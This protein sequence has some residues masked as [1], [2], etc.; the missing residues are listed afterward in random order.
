MFSLDFVTWCFRRFCC[1]CITL[2]LPCFKT[3]GHT[4]LQ[5]YIPVHTY[6]IWNLICLNVIDFAISC[7]LCLLLDFAVIVVSVNFF[8]V[9]LLLDFAVI[10]LSF[11]FDFLLSME[12]L[13]NLQ[14][15]QVAMF[16]RSIYLSIMLQLVWKKDSSGNFSARLSRRARQ[17]F[18]LTIRV[19]HFYSRWDSIEYP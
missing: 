9:R 13:L 5:R 12:L 3:C 17:E 19:T 14:S 1:Q 6:F 18:T 16:F 10:M 15:L 11:C 7:L 4:L 2:I 8:S